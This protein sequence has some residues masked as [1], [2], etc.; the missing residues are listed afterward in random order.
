MTKIQ[1]AWLALGL[2]VAVTVLLTIRGA[3]KTKSLK[4]FAVG[5]RDIHPAFVGL[6]LTAQLTSV[7]TFVVNPGLI[8]AFGVSG[9]VGMGGAAS[10]GII[11]GLVFFS[12]RFRA[13][14][15]QVAAL[16]VPQWIGTR[17][18]SRGL[19]IFFA[20]LSMA[21]VSFVVLIIVAIAKV[22]FGML[23]TPQVARDAQHAL[24]LKEQALWLQQMLAVGTVVFV[25]SYVMLGGAN[26]SAYTNAIQAVI[27]LVVAVILILSGVHLFFQDGGLL[28]K[29]AAIKPELATV[30]NPKSLYFRNVFEVFLCN[31]VVGCAIVC[32]PHIVSKAL[33]LKEEKDVRTYLIVGLLAGVVFMLVMLV[34]LYARVSLKGNYNF[35]TVVVVYIIKN[36]S[37]GAQVLISIGL[38]AAGIST[39]EGILLALSTIFSNDL[40]LGLQKEAPKDEAEEE[41]RARRA[42]LFGRLGMALL[43]GLALWLA[44]GQLRNPTGK[45]VAIFGQYGVY[46]LFTVSFLPL[47][48]GM[49][50]PKVSRRA[51]VFGT[52][53]STVTYFAVAIFKI[54][55]M[56][57]NPAFLAT[58][59]TFAGWIVVGAMFLIGDRAEESSAAGAAKV[60]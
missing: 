39:L 51:V 8:Y 9:L 38:L 47:A 59:A 56:H 25:F 44:A 30:I 48:C 14:G 49:F 45:S 46:L 33:Y 11:L 58:M 23:I 13:M 57:N 40:Y 6:S 34:G 26:T 19:R 16:S 22:L 50:F 52:L 12:K 29:L 15:T 3:L 54:T 17:Y 7:A 10:L 32:Q 36:F 43:G 4:N 24:Q 21:L 42:L 1:I 55:F 35:D 2:Y 37:A 5:S 53:A 28:G 18:Q 41:V 31:F 20:I 27:M 60:A